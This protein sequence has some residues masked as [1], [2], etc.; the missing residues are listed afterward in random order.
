MT[1]ERWVHAIPHRL[2]SLFRRT[3]V[4][5]ELDDELRDHLERKAE[6]YRASGLNA[7]DARRAALRDIDGLELRKEQCRDAR[8]VRRIEDLLQDLRY[9]MRALRKSP[10][11]A[12]TAILTLALGIGANAAIFSVINAVLLRALPYPA[13]DRILTLAQNESLPD[14]EDIRQQAR[15]FSAVSGIT[16]QALDFTGAG[17]PVQISGGF[18]TA[19]LFRVLDIAP[20]IGRPITAQEDRFGG[21]ALVVL[22]HGFWTR[23]F[24]AD[25]AVLGRSIRLSGNSYTILGVIPL[26]F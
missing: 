16:R 2:R 3:I 13:S 26:D 9:A 4:E 18:C 14:L 6:Q 10:A 23:Y 21:P 19:D 25:P 22:T 8:H 7:D 1:F 24:T 5:R 17:E 20:S 15:S 11:F 12:A